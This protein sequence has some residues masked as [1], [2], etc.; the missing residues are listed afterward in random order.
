MAWHQTARR[1]LQAQW[2]ADDEAFRVFVVVPRSLVMSSSTK[3]E[4]NLISSFSWNAR[5]TI[6]RYT[7]TFVKSY[8]EFIH[9]IIAQT[10]TQNQQKPTT[11]WF[12][13]SPKYRMELAHDIPSLN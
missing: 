1:Y 5:G 6:R 7:V 2:G 9:Q 3:S 11:N 4:L 13:L 12:L 8:H 10:R